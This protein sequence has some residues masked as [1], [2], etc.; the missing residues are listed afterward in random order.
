MFNYL[1]IDWGK[2]KIG[3]ALADGENKIALAYLTLNND[4]NFFNLLQKIIKK[5]KVKYIIIG[6]PYYFNQTDNLIEI[7]RMAKQLEEKFFLKV[8]FQNEM[9]TT[10]SAQKNLKEKGIRN[11]KKLDNQESARIILQ[12]WLDRNLI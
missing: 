5:E 3:L 11:I 12:D 9:F 2:N 8:F 7:K 10:Q 1:G 4:N 6:V